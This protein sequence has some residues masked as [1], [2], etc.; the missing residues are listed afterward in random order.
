MRAVKSKALRSRAASLGHVIEDPLRTIKVKPGERPHGQ[1]VGNGIRKYRRDTVRA[2]RAAKG[3][4]PASVKPAFRKVTSKW[5][6][7]IER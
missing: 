1:L 4:K 2:E 6:S 7:E 3:A 5:P